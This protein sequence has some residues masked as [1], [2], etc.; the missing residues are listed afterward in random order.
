MGERT[1]ADPWLIKPR[2]TAVVTKKGKRIRGALNTRA[3]GGLSNN[4]GSTLLLNWG[5]IQQGVYITF[6]SGL[7]EALGKEFRV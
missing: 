1:T 5:S 4:K 6:A 2:P 3:T 7:R